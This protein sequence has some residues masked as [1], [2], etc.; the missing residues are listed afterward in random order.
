MG[1]GFRLRLDGLLFPLR[2]L[3]SPGELSGERS[4]EDRMARELK[5]GDRVAWRSSGGGSVGRI[6][7]ELTAPA[8]IKG[9][10]VAASEDNPEYL[11]RSEKSGT[12]AAHKPS[13]LRRMK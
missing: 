12:I 6:E 10:A 7:R 2:N 1:P 4:S 8:K 11:V 13:E 3:L 9:H 5:I